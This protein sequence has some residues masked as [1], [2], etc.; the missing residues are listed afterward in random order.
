MEHLN[1]S[2]SMRVFAAGEPVSVVLADGFDRLLDYRAPEGGARP[3]D[4]VEV[5]LG[6]RRLLGAVWGAGQGDCAPE[7]LR[8]VTR[9]LDSPPLGQAMREFLGRA[10]DYTLTPLGVMLR[11]ATRAPA[12]RSSAPARRRCG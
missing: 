4:L 10:A 1:P 5:P 8:P 3:G 11:L 2:E 6:P 7:K 9:V 12:A